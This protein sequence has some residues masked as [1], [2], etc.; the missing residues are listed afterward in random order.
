MTIFWSNQ[1]EKLISRQHVDPAGVSRGGS[2]LPRG[3]GEP[4]GHQHHGGVA[5]P[6]HQPH[7]HHPAPCSPPHIMCIDEMEKKSADS[8]Q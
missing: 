2:G 7:P 5:P 8:W 4:G 1:W 6:P 3:H